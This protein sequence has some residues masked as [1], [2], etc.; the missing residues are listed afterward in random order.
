MTW[1]PDAASRLLALLSGSPE[2][3]LPLGVV[4]AELGLRA[5]EIRGLVRDARHKGRLVAC[6]EGRVRVDEARRPLRPSDLASR[7]PGVLGSRVRLFEEVGSTND[8]AWQQAEGPGLPHGALIL[9]ESQTAGRG[10][11]GRAWFSPRSAGLW[12]SV[13]VR[14]DL[15]GSRLP[16]LTQMTGVQIALALERAVG[17]ESLVKWPNDLLIDGRKAA[18]IL[19][20]ARSS[21]S[22]PPLAVIGV[23]I[24][25][26][27]TEDEF[28]PDLQGTATSLRAVAGAPLDRAAILDAVLD[29]MEEGYRALRAGD[30]ASLEEA[31][32]ARSAVLGRRVRIRGPQE[33]WTG[34]VVE[35]TLSKG[36]SLR[37]E[38]GG[39]RR[40][41]GEAIRSLDLLEAP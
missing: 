23:G 16:L 21:G 1:L 24:D 4:S 41:P 33:A 32:L 22:A 39:V 31:L 20:E 37:E 28:P 2:G 9:A 17:L 30:L 7:A 35:Q 15:E 29:A 11:E 40:I 25:V 27:Q 19:T 13:A 34:R 36:L 6:E 3:S 14:P 10:R 18:G 8:A 26:N 12:F 38:E 5:E